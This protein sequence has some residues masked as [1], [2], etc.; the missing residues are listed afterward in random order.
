[1]SWLSEH[2][3]LWSLLESCPTPKTKHIFSYSQCVTHINEGVWAA[4]CL[5][6][7]RL[8]LARVVPSAFESRP[9]RTMMQLAVSIASMVTMNAK[10]LRPCTTSPSTAF[11]W[12]NGCEKMNRLSIESADDRQNRAPS[13]GVLLY[14]NIET[15]RTQI[16]RQADAAMCECKEA[17]RNRDSFYV[18]FMTDATDLRFW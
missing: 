7:S 3:A 2:R 10:S 6:G 5:L 16:N 11:V 9:E 14:D 15:S 17:D 1:M 12:R 8:S 4:Q 18:I 13:I